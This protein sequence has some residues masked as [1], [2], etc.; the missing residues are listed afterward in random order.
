[1]YHN[2]TLSKN[3]GPTCY[4]YM[5]NPLCFWQMRTL[6]NTFWQ[7]IENNQPQVSTAHLQCS[8][9]CHVYMTSGKVGSMSKCSKKYKISSTLTWR[10]WLNRALTTFPNVRKRSFS[11][12]EGCWLSSVSHSSITEAKDMKDANPFFLPFFC[13]LPSEMRWFYILNFSSWLRVIQ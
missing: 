11:C 13:F 6:V 3:N 4:R 10:S 5:L 2:D 1:M 7:D 12:V 8:E 9:I